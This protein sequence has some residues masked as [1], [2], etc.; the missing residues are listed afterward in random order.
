MTSLEEYNFIRKFCGNKVQVSKAVIFQQFTHLTS[1]LWLFYN[2]FRTC[3]VL[4]IFTNRP[5]I[6]SLTR[7]LFKNLLLS[8]LCMF[9]VWTGSLTSPSLFHHIFPANPTAK[10]LSSLC[11]FPF[12]RLPC[13]DYCTLD[14]IQH[15]SP[16]L[17]AGWL[18]LALLPCTESEEH[19]QAQVTSVAHS[20]ELTWISW[21]C[22]CRSASTQ[23]IYHHCLGNSVN[24]AQQH[25]LENSAPN[26]CSL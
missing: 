2:L 6:F 22:L 9:C 5:C 18:F 16:L 11:A 14:S 7:W 17:Q 12:T 3:N 8:V 15:L 13:P 21:N 24:S 23:V 10:V 19:V 1:T 4:H 20:N 25:S 26:L